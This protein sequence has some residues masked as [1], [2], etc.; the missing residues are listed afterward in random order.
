MS[1]RFLSAK[2][3]RLRRTSP[4]ELISYALK[5]PLML[6]EDALARRLPALRRR[7]I[8]VEP[9]RI[10]DSWF[11]L[12][13]QA[14]IDALLADRGAGKTLDG[15]ADAAARHRFF[16][17]GLTLGS[18]PAP[19]EASERLAAMKRTLRDQGRGGPTPKALEED[20]YVPVAWSTDPR[21]GHAWPTDVWTRRLDLF[22]GDGTDVK[23]PWEL[24]RF[25]FLPWMGLHDRRL[26]AE[27]RT[28]E[29]D[30]HAAEAALLMLDWI[31]A[32]PARYG[33]HWRYPMEVSLRAW[34][35]IWALRLFGEA[36]AFQGALRHAICSSLVD[37][38]MLV[39]VY[40]RHSPEKRNN[41]YL[42]YAVGG[43]ALAC[44][45]P[46]SPWTDRLLAASVREIEK[47]MGEQISADGGCHE[48]STAYQRMV[49]EFFVSAAALV[50]G[51]A[52]ARRA[53]LNR[54]L[55]HG[56]RADTPV[57][58][59]AFWAKLEAML[60]LLRAL[61]GPDG[62]MPI[63]GDCDSGRLHKLV[64]CGRFDEATGRFAEDVADARGVIASGEALLHGRLEE[65]LPDAAQAE[66][67][68]LV[69]RDAAPKLVTEACTAARRQA[70]GMGTTRLEEARFAA[71]RFRVDGPEDAAP[72][73]LEV[74]PDFGAAVL[75]RGPF[76]LCARFLL[77][78]RAPTGHLHCDETSFVLSVKGLPVC[79]DAGSPIYV[80]DIG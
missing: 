26:R 79:V 69:G 25:Q 50:E 13:P 24:C 48:R 58:S 29:A 64:P 76:W 77:D 37:H 46:S 65:S 73:P 19:T 78:G 1:M 30:A 75:A 52:P 63:I 14:E 80:A 28:E 6:A 53:T 11:P 21:T 32:N 33:L 2:I 54:R 22:P 41:H 74:F 4:S 40:V 3:D 20:F 71:I 44:C 17:F 49:T 66:A 9:D 36:D 27:G 72:A 35:W 39:D 68:L 55:G 51:L 62:S 67:L 18:P 16:L 47:E 15:L 56:D 31:A 57:F 10:V 23:I 61:T 12:P 38:A 45:F 8:P 7:A 5:K 59:N 60:R 34:N 43:V 70:N 42:S